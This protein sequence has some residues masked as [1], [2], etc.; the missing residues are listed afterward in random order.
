MVSTY[1]AEL[2]GAF[3]GD[4][5]MSKTNSGIAL[6][7]TGNP[8]DE[9]DYYNK[10]IKFLFKKVFSIE[11]TPRNFTYWSVYGI[12]I[13]KKKIIKKF[14]DS[15]MPVG[16]KSHSVKVP[17]KIL[18]N[19]KLYKSFLRGLFDTDGCISFGKSYNQNASKWQKATHHIPRISITTVS[20]HLAKDVHKMFNSLGLRFSLRTQKAYKNNSQ[21]YC[22][23]FGG[24]KRAKEF[25]K[26]IKPQNKRHLDKFERW[27]SQG[28]Y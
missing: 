19:K 7:I 27:L 14:I 5:W 16:E 6:F 20:E 9:K 21:A 23:E 26:K 10:R 12:Y 25:F 22:L 28:F 8:K 15:E 18:K 4:G 17:N 1:F 3:A 24:K 11:L 13:G 2:L